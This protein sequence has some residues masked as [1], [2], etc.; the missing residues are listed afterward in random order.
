MKILTSSV[1]SALIAF[2][3]F[4]AEI[5]FP[6][7]N[8]SSKKSEPPTVIRTSKQ[9]QT[10]TK[11]KNNHRKSNYPYSVTK[12]KPNYPYFVPRVKSA[13]GKT[14]RRRVDLSK[15]PRVIRVMK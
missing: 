9:K 7:T 8:S 15:V 1:I 14:S 12:R 13:K 10:K 5:S 2:I 4:Q 3:L 11:R 6:Q